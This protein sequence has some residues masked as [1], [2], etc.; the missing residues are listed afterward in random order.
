MKKSILS[1]AAMIAISCAVNAQVQNHPQNQ[2]TEV[3]GEEPMVFK[4]Q[5]EKEAKI[6][7]LEQ[8]IQK[9]LDQG[10]TKEELSRHFTE[11]QRAKTGIITNTTTK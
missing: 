11:L 2:A 8:L 9:R 5:A 3:R 1:I 7:Q 6:A 4:T 10:K